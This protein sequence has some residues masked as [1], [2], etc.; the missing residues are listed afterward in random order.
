M[1]M[2]QSF[3]IAKVKT[4]INVPSSYCICFQA[5]VILY[6]LNNFIKKRIVKDSVHFYFTFVKYILFESNHATEFVK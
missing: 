3:F 2:L 5:L 1:L 4:Q 6:L